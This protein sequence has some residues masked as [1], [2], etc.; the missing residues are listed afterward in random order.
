MTEH[1]I[2]SKISNTI[3]DLTLPFLRWPGG[4]RWLS[5]K[6]AYFIN[7]IG[8]KKYYEP[9]IGGG[10]VFF[11]V[12]PI[13]ATISDKNYKL[14]NSY[15]NVKEN[16]N[17]LIDK[18]REL[19][20]NKET[21]YRIRSLN[22]SDKL[23]QAVNFIFLNRLAFS[24]MYRENKKGKFNV[25]YGGDRDIHILW[26]KNIIRNASKVLQNVKIQCCDFE[27]IIENSKKG[28]LIYCD[29]AYTTS[30]KSNGFNKYNDT[31]FSFE[32]QERLAKT[33]FKAKRRGV[34]IIIS[35]AYHEN[36]IKLYEGI[37][38]IILDKSST[39]SRT[40]LGRK[41]IKESLFLMIGDQRKKNDCIDFF[42]NII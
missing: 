36:I 1:Q 4:K 15:V 35:N 5:K 16:P 21:Y 11:Q 33:C 13:N 30:H 19:T 39:I 41:K 26:K 9:F 42:N 22:S 23:E 3:D 18:I 32:D 8:F 24:G 38:Q 37:D 29:P 31:I 27:E 40:N 17:I 2:E 6:L 25:P 10:S 20:P 14:M 12:N 34:N 28:D 7:R